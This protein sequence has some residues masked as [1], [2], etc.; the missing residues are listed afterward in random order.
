MRGTLYRHQQARTKL[1][2]FV[3]TKKGKRGHTVNWFKWWHTRGTQVFDDFKCS[4]PLT[5]TVNL[6]EVV[7][8]KW[9]KKDARQQ[10]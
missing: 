3:M 8:S 10:T 7:R 1:M 5:P 2:S 4:A 9:A 6:A